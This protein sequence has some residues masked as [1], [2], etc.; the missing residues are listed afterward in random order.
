[1]CIPGVIVISLTLL[2]IGLEVVRRTQVDL[3]GEL[4]YLTLQVL[5]VLISLQ[6]WT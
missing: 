2:L 1:M 4:K 5:Y 3:S 6:S